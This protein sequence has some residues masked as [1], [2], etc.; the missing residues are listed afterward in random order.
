MGEDDGAGEGE[1]GARGPL[2]EVQLTGP[3]AA[4]AGG[5]VLDEAGQRLAV[6]QVECLGRRPGPAQRVEP[7]QRAPSTAMPR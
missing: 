4:P 2:P 6:D 5:P 7:G 3:V 1:V